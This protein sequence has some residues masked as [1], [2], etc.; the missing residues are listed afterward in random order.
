M[1]IKS[2]PFCG[3]RAEVYEDEYDNTTLYMVACADCGITTSGYDYEE[4]AIK[5]WNR[6][7]DE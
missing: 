5:D 7:V 1:I 3:G 6:R 2:C 4:D